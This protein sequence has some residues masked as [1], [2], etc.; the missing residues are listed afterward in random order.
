MATGSDAHAGGPAETPKTGHEQG[1]RG[2]DLLGLEQLEDGSGSG[3]GVS[4]ATSHL[5]EKSDR[6]A[7]VPAVDG[8]FNDKRKKR[9]SRVSVTSQAKTVSPQRSI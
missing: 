8:S 6:S 1:T 3:L 7:L 2:L 4:F 5:P 9:S